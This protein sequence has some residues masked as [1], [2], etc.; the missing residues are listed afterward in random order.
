MFFQNLELRNCRL[1]TRRLKPGAWVWSLQ[2]QSILKDRNVNLEYHGRKVR[3]ATAE[4]D[5]G[6][7]KLIQSKVIE[8]ALKHN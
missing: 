6:I 8:E 4:G 7:Y 5:A 3:S 2:L 1:G